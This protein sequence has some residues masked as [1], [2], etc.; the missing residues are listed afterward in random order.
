MVQDPFWKFCNGLFNALPLE[1][2]DY[3]Q[4]DTIADKWAQSFL[5]QPETKGALNFITFILS[6]WMICT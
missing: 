1:E 3:T 6:Y 5:E 4:L 2:F